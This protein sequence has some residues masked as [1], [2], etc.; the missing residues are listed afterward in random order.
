MR[1]DSPG[2][3]TWLLGA[4]ALWAMCAWLLGLLDMGGRI[5]PLADD[6]SLLQRLPQA[7]K[8]MPARLGPLPQYS[9]IGQRP[10]FSE[11]R[12]PQ[13]FFIDPT[14]E[15]DTKNTFDYV[16]TSVLIAPGFQMAILQ[17]SA[18]GESLRVKVGEAPDAAKGWILASLGARSAVFNGP[19]GERK[20]E[21]RV[22]NGVGGEAPS[23]SAG[24]NPSDTPPT[25]A[26]PM[27]DNM[28]AP[29][30]L[31]DPMADTGVPPPGNA[32]PPASKPPSPADAMSGADAK[33][34]SDQIDAIRKRIEARRAKLR[35][36]EMSPPSPPGKKP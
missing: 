1:T 12:R 4:I 29:P 17:P 34:S 5:D 9:E 27:P 11:N 14:G 36:D 10:L 20:L 8:T 2:A 18:G 16:L 6:P 30:P 23:A 15:A 21:L 19:D 3:K 31:P 22:F 7:G 35:Q 28:G 13:P 33:P 26:Q 24:N 32:A 25:M